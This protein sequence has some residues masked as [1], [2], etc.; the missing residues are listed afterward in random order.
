MYSLDQVRAVHKRLTWATEDYRYHSTRRSECEHGD[1]S[2]GFH[3]GEAAYH[4]RKIKELE[5]QVAQ[6]LADMPRQANPKEDPV[7]EGFETVGA[8]AGEGE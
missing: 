6:M 8:Y 3:S 2:V 1:C 7:A 4:E 5:A